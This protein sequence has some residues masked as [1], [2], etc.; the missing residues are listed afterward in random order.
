MNV[1]LENSNN[2]RK[3]SLKREYKKERNAKKFENFEIYDPESLSGKQLYY[4][5]Y[6]PFT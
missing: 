6:V 5:K 3:T 4:V 1:W 2:N